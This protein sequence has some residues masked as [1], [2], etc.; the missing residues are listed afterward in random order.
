MIMFVPGIAYFLVCETCMCQVAVVTASQRIYRQTFSMIITG[1][2][3]TVLKMSSCIS[4][5]K[6]RS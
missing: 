6:L 4:E 1:V 5:S 3:P 2:K